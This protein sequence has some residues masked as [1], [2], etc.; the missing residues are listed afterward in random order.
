[1]KKEQIVV[2]GRYLAKVSGRLVTVRVDE[3]RETE[4]RHYPTVYGTSRTIKSSTRYDVTNL[5]TGRHT[6]FRSA[7]KFQREAPAPDAHK[8]TAY[9]KSLNDADKR[10]MDELAERTFR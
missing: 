3:I 8:Q 5:V 7:A 4:T 6:T 9:Y 10:T 1:M 2:G